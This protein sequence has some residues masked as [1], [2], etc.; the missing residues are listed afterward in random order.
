LPYAFFERTVDGAVRD[1][2]DELPFDV[3]ETWEW[4][5]L[6]EVFSVIMGQSPDGKSVSESQ[7]GIEFHQG[8]V[9]FTNVIIGLSNQ[10]TSQP[11]KIAPANSVLL[12]VRAP[13]GK[14][15]ITDRKL[16]IGRGLCSV[17]PLA[18]MSVDFAYRLLETYEQIF[19]KQATGTTFVAVTGEVVIN[20]LIPL[21]PLAEQQ[22]IVARIE[23]LLPH[24]ADYDVVEQKLTA[25]NTTF[26]DR[27]K[28]SI[29]QAAV[30][31]KLVPQDPAD[32]PASVLLERIRAEKEAQIKAGKIKRDKH[33]SVIFRRD[34]SHYEKLDGIER[35]IDD[36]IPFDVPE[37]WAWARLGTLC[38]FGDCENAES[39]TIS[40]EA[41]LL[42]LEDI[43]KDSG[44]LIHRK[45]KSEVKSLS[46]KHC[47]T[48]GQVLYS[49]L[50]PYLNK[51]IIADEDGY[52]TSE[53]LPLDFGASVYN[54]YAQIY[55]MSPF[56]VG[57][58][59][60][61]SYG[62]KMPRLGTQDGKNA[63]VP[64]PPIKEQHRI[65]A[66]VD[67]VIPVCESL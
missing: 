54:R 19:I 21:P 26:P 47:F 44:R 36:E 49:K 37:N 16:C 60:Q 38:N 62:V 32:E 50:R 20:Q 2:T 51:V 13:V 12:C 11:T 58:A 66:Q 46:T 59:T 4:V 18:G 45:K 22:R 7:N 25:L 3:P 61:C 48:I 17:E 10:T 42:D 55:L 23:E 6:G 67:A 28:K 57:Y 29:L 52:C 41:W 34:N 39:E 14:V 40:P 24:I 31:G 1:I 15:N 43:E 30:Q 65:L 33:E 63:L 64:L 27:L 5:R 9:F 53:I 8:K 35:C 56:F